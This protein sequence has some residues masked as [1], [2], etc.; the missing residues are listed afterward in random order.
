MTRPVLFFDLA[1]TLE[2]RLPSGRWGLWPGADVLL[3][4]LAK[5]HDLYLTTGDSPAGARGFLGETGLAQNFKGIHAALPGG[6]KPFG[7]IAGELGVDPA[8]CLAIGDNP[9]SDTA[10]DT[11]QVVTLLVD[12]G[13]NLVTADRVGEVVQWLGS[14]GSFLSTFEDQLKGFTS[15]GTTP[16]DFALS[17]AKLYEFEV[18]GGGLLGWWEKT[19][20]SRRAVVML[21][22]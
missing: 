20:Q 22:G 6:G 14:E 5:D 17:Q 1:G 18:G 8:R 3:T 12:H 9:V 15:Q 13:E 2:L 7:A 11:D 10:G 19:A 21:S 4:N 16:I